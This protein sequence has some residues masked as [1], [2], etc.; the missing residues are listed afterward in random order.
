VS[1]AAARKAEDA[2]LAD[3]GEM[4]E[5]A[6]RQREAAE[7]KYGADPPEPFVPEEEDEEEEVET[8]W[9]EIEMLDEEGQPVSGLTYEVK[10]LGDRNDQVARGTLDQNGRARVAGFPAVEWCEV[11]FPDLDSQAWEYL[12]SSRRP[13][14]VR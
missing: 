14:P 3:L 9:I 10:I 11:S 13:G 2:D 7:G 4:T 1:P 5:V 8:T 12:M 6:A